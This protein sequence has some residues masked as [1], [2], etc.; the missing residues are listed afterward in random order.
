MI[1]NY[2]NKSSI[3]NS[4]GFIYRAAKRRRMMALD[5]AKEV[6]LEL[7]IAPKLSAVK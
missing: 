4:V 5:N 3:S 1:K 7:G 2:A 6:K